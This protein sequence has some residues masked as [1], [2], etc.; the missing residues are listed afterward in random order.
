MYSI[1]FIFFSIGCPGVGGCPSPRACWA[2]PRAGPGCMWVVG[3][4]RKEKRRRGDIHGKRGGG[5]RKLKRKVFWE[6]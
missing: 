1:I 2:Y 6:L 3:E 5:K 4:K